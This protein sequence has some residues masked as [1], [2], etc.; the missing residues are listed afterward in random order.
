MNVS[1]SSRSHPEHPRWLGFLRTLQT[2]VSTPREEA[3]LLAEVDTALRALIATDDWLDPAWRL[4]G[5]DTYRQYPLYIDPEGRFSVVSFVWGPGHRTP[6]HNHGTWGVIGVLTG[7]ELCTEYDIP[8]EGMP[9]T[10]TGRHLLEVGS[11]DKVSPAVGDIHQVSN[12][13]D[14]QTSISIHVYGRDIGTAERN[15]YDPNN[16]KLGHFVSGY[17]QM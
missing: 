16:G 17:S 7:A 6:I 14:G 13:K 2:L 8:T 15:I 10:P 5:A 9:M 11:T 3:L 4:A 1:L 12:A